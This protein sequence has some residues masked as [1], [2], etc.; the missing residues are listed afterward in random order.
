MIWSFRVSRRKR[1]ST[2]YE[3]KPAEASTS[4]SSLALIMSILLFMS[5][6][7]LINAMTVDAQQCYLP[8]GSKSPDT[9]CRPQSS[10]QASACCRSTDICLDNSL[11]LAQTGYALLTRGSCTDPTW[12]SDECPRDYQD[13]K[14]PE[15][16]CFSSIRVRS[17]LLLKLLQGSWPE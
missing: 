2:L 8:N 16:P 14:I 9:P 7:F 3:Q 5:I 1:T 15:I 10:D 12:Q 11:C 6:C 13:G 17:F 4:T